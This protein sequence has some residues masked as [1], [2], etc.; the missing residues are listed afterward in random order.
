MFSIDQQY[1]RKSVKK[2]R[3]FYNDAVKGARDQKPYIYKRRWRVR[4]PHR[5]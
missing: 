2:T 1:G 4:S 5:L 3:L